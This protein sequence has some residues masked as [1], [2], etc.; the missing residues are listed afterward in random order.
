MDNMVIAVS[1]YSGAG[2]STV[3][4]RLAK[5]LNGSALYFDDYASRRDFPDDLIAWLKDGGNPN[6][7]SAPLLYQHLVQLR[8]GQPIELV[9]G[10]GWG[11][12]YGIKPVK[13]VQF[14]MPSRLIILEEPF[15]R[16]RDEIKDLIDMVVYLDI[17]PEIALGRRVLELVHYLKNDPEVLL[18]F[19]DHYLF[20]YL[21][22]GVRDMFIEVGKKVK[23]NSDLIIDANQNVE[24]IVIELSNEIRKKRIE[25]L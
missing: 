16:E 20:D 8:N 6:V 3:V 24:D 9:K 1:G 18:N 25:N 2:K 12:E 5:V 21:Y 22:R 17:E 4:S 14:I 13:E 23:S 15:G 7:V 10:G 11:K 19:L